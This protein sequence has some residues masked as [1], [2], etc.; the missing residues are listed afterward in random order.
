MENA[1]T[2]TPQPLNATMEEAMAYLQLS[3]RTLQYYVERGLLKP[4]RFGKLRRFRWAEIGKIEKNGVPRT[5]REL[6]EA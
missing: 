1:P 4:V 6:Q 5:T 3:Q 2:N